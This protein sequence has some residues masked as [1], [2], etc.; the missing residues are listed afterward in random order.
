MPQT[1]IVEANDIADDIIGL[2]K[3]MRPRVIVK[4]NDGKDIQ[5]YKK[6]IDDGNLLVEKARELIGKLD[7][8]NE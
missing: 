3:R 6:T 1:I 4:D 8:K 7:G 2:A 5:K